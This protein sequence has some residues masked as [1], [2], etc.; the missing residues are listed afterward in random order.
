M[1]SISPTW[2]IRGVYDAR[3]AHVISRAFVS[4]LFRCKP[5]GGHVTQILLWT[6]SPR[7]L[8]FNGTIYARRS[9]QGWA[10]H[11]STMARSGRRLSL[12]LTCISSPR[13]VWC[14]V[15]SLRTSRALENVGIRWTSW[16]RGRTC[17]TARYEK[18]SLWWLLRR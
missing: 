1:W 9:D 16:T 15:T 6:N 8:G 10:T 3:C 7:A 13:L 11:K 5:C 17:D 18:A 14:S 2:T 12:N 4:T